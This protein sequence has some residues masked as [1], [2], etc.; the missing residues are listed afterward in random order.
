MFEGLSAALIS[1]A[2][3]VLE[4]LPRSPFTILDEMSSSDFYEILQF[5]NWFIPINTFVGIFE[6]W[7]LCVGLYYGYQV[8]FRWIK[9]IE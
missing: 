5:V 2:I 1:F 3:S 9:V 4:L 6:G 8:I 7:L